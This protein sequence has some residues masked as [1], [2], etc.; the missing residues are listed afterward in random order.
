[1]PLQSSGCA[2]LTGTQRFAARFPAAGAA[3]FYRRAQDVLVSNVGIGTYLGE[4]DDAT[5]AGY[6]AAVQTAIAC[7]ANLIDTSLNYRDQ[8]SERAVGA[9]IHGVPRDEIVVCTKGGYLVRD[10]ITPGT[11]DRN[12]VVGGMHSIAPAFLSDQLERSRDNLGLQ[13]IDI[14]YLHNPETQLEVVDQA[15]FTIRIRA[16]FDRL[17]RAVSDGHIRFYGTATW[18]GY[19][20][21]AARGALSLR[22]LTGAA[23]EIAGDR[24][25]FRFIQLPLNL[26]MTEALTRP[27]EDGR[28]ILDLAAELEISVIAS[29]SLLQSRLSRNLPAEVAAQFPGLATDAQRSIQF[30]R[31]TPGITSAL[32]GMSNPMHVRENLAVASLA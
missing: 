25:H 24:H 15:E 11:L 20:C 32:V 3:G 17:E 2:T 9:A 5:D 19:R 22:T 6:A 4:I 31:S 16:A 30:T 13:T 23:R 29:A 21:G 8:R 26:A 27:G 18:N 12:G 1:M 10:A 28:L 7:G 14:Y